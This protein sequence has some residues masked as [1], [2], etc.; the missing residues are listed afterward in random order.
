M[1]HRDL[2]LKAQHPCEDSKDIVEAWKMRTNQQP[3]A[4]HQIKAPLFPVSAPNMKDA[5]QI[6]QC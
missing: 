1:K 3:L 4:E 6:G 5:D 2:E